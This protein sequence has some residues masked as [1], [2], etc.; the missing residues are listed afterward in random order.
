M[1]VRGRGDEAGNEAGVGGYDHDLGDVGAPLGLE[2]DRSLPTA[3]RGNPALLT[4]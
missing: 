1:R 2:K 3:S 4:P